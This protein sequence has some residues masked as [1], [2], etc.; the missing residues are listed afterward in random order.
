[1]KI[2]ILLD[3]AHLSDYI[4]IWMLFIA[5]LEKCSS[6]DWICIAAKMINMNLDKKEA[7]SDDCSPL[8]RQTQLT[9]K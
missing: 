9:L 4:I 1:M 8:H 6:I 5:M 3:V 2:Y 7:N